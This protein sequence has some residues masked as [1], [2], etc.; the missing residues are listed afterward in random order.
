MTHV[1][2]RRI[3]KKMTKAIRFHQ[4][5]NQV[6]TRTWSGPYHPGLGFVLTVLNPNPLMIRSIFLWVRLIPF[7]FRVSARVR[8]YHLNVFCC[9]SQPIEWFAK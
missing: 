8:N 2:K 9:P 1:T 3:K 5:P 4:N 7:F 6:R